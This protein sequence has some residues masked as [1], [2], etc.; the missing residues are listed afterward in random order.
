[1]PG[2]AN[3]QAF[4]RYSYV[5]GNPL[6]Y[7]DPT[8]HYCV[9]DDE[10]C[11]DEGGNGPAPNGTGGSGGSNSGGNGGGNPNDDYDPNPNC[12]GCEDPIALLP[13]QCSGSGC[14]LDSSFP[15]GPACT[16]VPYCF[17]YPESPEPYPWLPDYVALEGG[18]P[19]AWIFG[20][21][22]VVT[23]DKYNPIIY[24]G[25]GPSG[26]T[27]PVLGMDVN[28]SLSVGYF[29]DE[30]T[31]PEEAFSFITEWSGGG[32]VGA[33]VGYCRVTGDP[34]DG[35]DTWANQYGVF[36][37]QAG[38]ALPYSVDLIHIP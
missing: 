36:T 6:R 2:A 30:N 33:I 14:P 17:V 4:N 3:P 38:V 25:A 37:P 31:T 22:G 24:V 32:C 18:W 12:I 1:M 34:F 7:T 19:V 10:D 27:S 29:S 21:D 9:G 23:V 13:G 15:P 28:V 11:A 20:I 35:H 5:L 8:G 16:E 26:G